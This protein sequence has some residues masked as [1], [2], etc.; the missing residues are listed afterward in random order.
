MNYKRII[1]FIITTVLFYLL[2]VFN[3]F[4]IGEKL[5]PTTK[6]Y[7]ENDVQEEIE[8]TGHASANDNLTSL[9]ETSTLCDKITFNGKYTTTNK[10]LY[11]KAIGDIVTFIDDNTTQEKKIEDTI[12]NITINN[13]NGTR[14]WYA[15]RDS[16]ILNLWSVKSKKE[17]AEL[18][19]HEMGHITDLWYIQWTSSKKDKN[20]TEFGKIVFEIN[21]SSLLFYK[22]SRSKETIRK[23]EAKK[24]D[25]CSWYGMTDPFED[26]AE[27]FNLYTNHNSFFKKIAKTNTILKKKYNFI[28][29]IV[30]GQYMNAN[31]QDTNI[32][33]NNISRRPRDTTKLISN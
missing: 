21:D 28:A 18:S 29:A 8:N 1:K 9:C 2:L 20:F 7:L 27:C 22:F 4:H 3:I 13:Q 19:S 14:R 33:A 6:D 30:D 15:T 11:T 10:Y 24:K 31:S 25:F 16:I 17:F 23:A 32:L 5:L 12:S 26:F